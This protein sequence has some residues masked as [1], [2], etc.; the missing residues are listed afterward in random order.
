MGSAAG[1]RTPAGEP[2]RDTGAAPTDDS[3]S[4]EWPQTMAPD[5]YHG[6]AGEM[7]KAISPH[8]ESDPAALAQTR[9]D[10]FPDLPCGLGHDHSPHTTSAACRP[11]KPLREIAQ[12]AFRQVCA[13]EG[14]AFRP[15]HAQ[16]QEGLA[17][18]FA[19]SVC[20]SSAR[21]SS[22]VMWPM[23]E[24]CASVAVTGSFF[25]RVARV[26]VSH[27]VLVVEDKVF[28]C[29]ATTRRTCANSGSM[30]S[31]RLS[32]TPFVYDPP[33]S[34]QTS[35]PSPFRS[36]DRAPAT[37]SPRRSTVPTLP[38]AS[39]ALAQRCCGRGPTTHL[40][41]PSMFRRS[42][43]RTGWGN[44]DRLPLAYKG[45]ARPIRRTT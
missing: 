39:S 17:N 45:N 23:I 44:D 1:A 31:R 42:A 28:P 25:V 34:R 33:L 30:T 35:C 26:P 24:M 27:A 6:I 43:G 9:V 21:S 4:T 20:V 7:V 12:H 19:V 5:A 11:L 41:V 3:V 2:I 37:S 22:T 13:T 15:L 14:Q 16:E 38:A 18:P 29:R 10:A 40:C 32:G 8:T 36:A